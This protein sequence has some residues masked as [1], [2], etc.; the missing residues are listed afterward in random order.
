MDPW[1]I[2]FGVVAGVVIAVGGFL[3]VGAAVMALFRWAT[4]LVTPQNSALEDEDEID[5]RFY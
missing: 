4:E 1:S 5:H 2:S 3:L